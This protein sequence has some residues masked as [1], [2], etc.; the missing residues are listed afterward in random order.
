M[1]LATADARNVDQ[2]AYWNGAGGRNWVDRQEAQEA[3][4][5]PVSTALIERATV[6]PGEHVVDVGCGTGP[7]TIE[8]G[9]VVGPTGRVLGIDVSEPMLARARA[10]L[11]PGSPVSLVQADA[12][13]YDFPR[14][15]FDLLFSR[16]GV[17]F[18]AEP[19]K[20]FANLRAAL[21]PGGRL[22]FACWRK[23]EENPWLTLPLRAALEHAPPLPQPGP[24]DPGMFSF[25]RE[26][27]VRRI[28]G[29]AGF[30]AIRAE[31]VDF[32]FDIGRGRGLDE[33]AAAA[34]TI[35]PAGRALEGQPPDIHRAALASVRRALAP[36][37][38]GAAIPLAAAVWIVTATSP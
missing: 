9:A 2:I 36:H 31:P 14:A 1:A 21:R 23:P 4:L 28:L 29:D 5:A 8:L 35:G 37:Q 15:S 18:F 24:E 10:R 7:T 25:A 12:T 11:Q 13:A 26:D 22:A 30:T 3:S 32:E 27:R 19:A 38:K 20:T 6:R 33:A 34:T 16:F 17:M